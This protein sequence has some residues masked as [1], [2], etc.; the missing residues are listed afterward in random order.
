MRQITP[1]LVIIVLFASSFSLAGQATS[2]AVDRRVALVIG[3]SEYD[4]GP[5]LN[6]SNDA[7]AM[8]VALRET[9]FE[10]MEY[11][12]L[13]N[14]AD[15]KRAIR[16]FGR[17]IQ[18]GGVG[19]FY[20]AGHGIQVNGKNYLVPIKAQIYA[21]EEVEYESVD[22]GFVMSQMEIARNRM[23]II[24]LDACRNNPFAR[25]WRSAAT[26]L[27]FINAPT[28]TMIAYS[29]APGS[30]ASDGTGANGLYTEEL[31]KQIQRGGLKIEDVFKQVR[32][33]VLDKSNN[34]QTPWES[35]SLVGDF[36]FI[37]PVVE[38]SQPQTKTET[39]A[40]F[41]TTNIST[42]ASTDRVEWRKAPDGRYFFFRNGVEISKNTSGTTV[43]NDVLVFDKAAEKTYLLKNY[44]SAQAKLAH[45][46]EELYSQN[47]AFWRVNQDNWYWFYLKGV[48]ITNQTTIA[49]F[50]DHRVIFHKEEE[51]YYKM[52]NSKNAEAFTL[53]PATSVFSPNKTLWWADE[54]YYYLY[55]DGVQIASRTWSNWKGNDIIVH[56]EENASSYLL[57][58][59]Y[60]H[61]DQTLRPAEILNA[62]GLITCSRWDEIYSLFKDHK[63][64]LMGGSASY[65]DQD[66]VVFDTNFYQ[67]VVFKDYLNAPNHTQ[68]AGN[69]IYSRSGAI[70]KRK[71]GIYYLYIRGVLQTGDMVTA[72]HS[73][74]GS[75]LEVVEAATGTVWILE[76]YANRDDNI[77]RPAAIKQNF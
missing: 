59:Y 46:P 58:D 14:Q 7:R 51:K 15:M 8:A 71:E 66:L 76:D 62:P 38:T 48:D 45:K 12:N 52:T 47:N 40:E 32:S 41:H 44:N 25:S 56:D 10:V 57:K 65:S 30:V 43:D 69:T 74:T 77:L 26:G 4:T 39:P 16:E 35:S 68:I 54:K 19:L 23:N 63:T 55:I 27:A 24:I 2:S 18:N 53:Y 1:V 6:P 61:T 5:L 36:Y 72:N 67:A 50:G 9:G 33:E 42:E 17:K 21:E 22:V 64:Y 20:Y 34:M 70:W 11:I 3:N 31:L 37:R 60:N 49:Y 28:G 13:A 75:D 29:T 73:L